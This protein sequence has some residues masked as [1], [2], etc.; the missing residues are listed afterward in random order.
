VGDQCAHSTVRGG[1]TLRNLTQPKIQIQ[2]RGVFFDLYGTLLLFADP[3]ASW[4]DWLE[5]FYAA[6]G[7]HGLAVSK[8]VFADRCN[9]FFGRDESPANDDGFTVFER[10][11]HILAE[12]LGLTIPAEEI[13]AIAPGI[14]NAWQNHIRPD[15]E[16]A[17]VLTVLQRT[18]TLALISNF[19]HPPHVYR[20]L[21][22]QGLHG[23]FKTIVISG[24]VGCKKPHPR[25]FELALHQT[26]LSAAEVVYVGD[27]EEDVTGAKA[28]R[29]TPI[30]I[31]RSGNCTD[32]RLL[33]YQGNEAGWG[34]S[35]APRIHGAATTVASLRA[36]IEVIT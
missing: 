27:T 25:I 6:L 15:P 5:A 2:P 28:A 23:Y 24:E 26:G 19:D 31:A 3:K 9:R 7:S 16:A 12:A 14:V 33:D 1:C 30:L 35:A 17:E 13:K 20:V 10:R 21:R 8:A 29:I 18:K 11:M 4:A 32:P 34:P 22:E 36:L